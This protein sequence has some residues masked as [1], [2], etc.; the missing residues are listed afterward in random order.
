M[1]LDPT[2]QW[3]YGRWAVET[4]SP[5]TN[6]PAAYSRPQWGHGFPAVE[7]RS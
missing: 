1:V 7:T 5:R 4:A 3:A 6:V 2:L